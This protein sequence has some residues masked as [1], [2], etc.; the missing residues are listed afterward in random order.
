MEFVVTSGGGYLNLRQGISD[1]PDPKNT[2]GKVP[3]DA[4]EQVSVNGLYAE[5]AS[6]TFVVYPNATLAVWEP[7][8][9]LGL[10]WRDGNHWFVLEKLGDPYPIEWITKEQLLKLAEGLVDERPAGS[11]PPLDPEYLTTV[12]Q[13]ELLA[14]FDIPGANLATSRIRAQTGGLDG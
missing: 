14:G 7:G 13:A 3:S 10:A 8:G 6:G 5:I 11:V 4:V 2:W 9:Q 12:E 1:F